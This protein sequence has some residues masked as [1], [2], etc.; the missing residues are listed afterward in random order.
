[1]NKISPVCLPAIVYGAYYERSLDPM[2]PDAIAAALKE[3]GLL[4]AL[5]NPFRPQ[6]KEGWM[7]IDW[8]ENPIGWGADG[9]EF[10]GPVGEFDFKIGPHGRLCAYPKERS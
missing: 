9:E 5:L 6:R 3:R 2:H 4:G 7:L 8:H 1:M 10:T